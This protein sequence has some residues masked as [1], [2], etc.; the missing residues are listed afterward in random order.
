ML[1]LQ[2]FIV[3]AMLIGSAFFSGMETGVVSVNPLRLAHLKRKGVPQ[4]FIIDRFR[5]HPDHLLGTALVGNNICNVVASVTAVSLG[6][7]LLGLPGYTI[8]YILLTLSMLMFGEYLPKSWFQSR[9][10]RRVMPLIRL[11]QFIGYLLYPA[12]RVLTLLARLFFPVRVQEE[13]E[14]PL[15]TRDEL[16]HLTEESA[17]V[18]SL[19]ARGGQMMRKVFELSH[20]TCQEV[21]VPLADIRG[22]T[23][24][25]GAEEI[26]RIAR[27]EQHSRLPVFDP[28]LKRYIG[29]VYIFD[30]LADS[31]R[32]GKTARSYM[33]P[34]QFVE[35]ATPAESLLPRM[36]LS[37]QPLALVTDHGGAVIGLVTVED[38]L[39]EIVGP[40]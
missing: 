4:A 28:V 30:V 10:A 33:R 40:L 3:V 2:F 37:K 17:A 25:V 12:S 39:E 23:P 38:L 19:S 20:K 35:G 27:S 31:N 21:M 24:D 8:A 26:I 34:P 36:R 9:P 29:M 1:T 18:G 14:R 22:V 11:F 6:T 15:I 7:A 32:G 13:G 5:Q 16:R